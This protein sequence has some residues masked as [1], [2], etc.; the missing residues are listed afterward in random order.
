MTPEIHPSLVSVH[1]PML[2]GTTGY[3]SKIAASDVHVVMGAAPYRVED[4]LGSALLPGNGMLHLA[5]SSAE[6]IDEVQVWET[7]TKVLKT[8]KQEFGKRSMPHRGRLEPVLAALEQT[9][10]GETLL[11]L[12]GRMAAALMQECRILTRIEALPRPGCGEDTQERLEEAMRPFLT[13]RSI[14]VLGP[15]ARN[16]MLRRP[17]APTVVHC[18]TRPRRTPFLLDLVTVDEIGDV[19]ASYTLEPL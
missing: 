1:Q 17:A 5:L 12:W 2:F 4:R 11:T 18:A 16:Y 6:R 9:V 19:L 7:P 14:L 13:P 15:G 10:P 8:L 3:W